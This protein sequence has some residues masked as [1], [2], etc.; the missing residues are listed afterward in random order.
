LLQRDSIYLP[1]K[2]I[3]R[4]VEITKDR[5]VPQIIRVPFLDTLT[6]SDG[7]VIVRQ[8]TDDH[9]KLHSQ[10]KYVKTNVTIVRKWWNYWYL[11]VVGIVI[12]MVIGIWAR[13]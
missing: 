6:V 8:W 11:I 2:T 12:G 7:N 4:I 1:A 13:K 3:Q 5:L 10:F 9:G